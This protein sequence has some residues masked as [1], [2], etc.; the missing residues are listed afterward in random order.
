MNNYI[1]IKSFS[2]SI[3]CAALLLSAPSYGQDGTIEVN[4]DEPLRDSGANYYLV[5][6]LDDGIDRTH[7]GIE[8]M[9]IKGKTFYYGM[10]E[11]AIEEL[12]DVS[13][14]NVAVV[15]TLDVNAAEDATMTTT[16]SNDGKECNVD[17]INYIYEGNKLIEMEVTKPLV[18]SIGDFYGITFDT[19][20]KLLGEQTIVNTYDR[21]LGKGMVLY[22]NKSA[23]TYLYF[24]RERVKAWGVTSKDY[25]DESNWQLKYQSHPA[26]F[27]N[28]NSNGNRINGGA[29]TAQYGWYYYAQPTPNGKH[30]YKML[31]SGLEPTKLSEDSP[32]Y[33]NVYGDWLYYANMSDLTLNGEGKIY[34]IKTDGSERQVLTTI[35]AQYLIADEEALY[36]CSQGN[37]D[38]IVPGLY[39]I[40]KEGGELTFLDEG[41]VAYLNSSEEAL[42]YLIDSKGELDEIKKIDKEGNNLRTYM[43]GHFGFLYME[44]DA[45]FYSNIDEGHKAYVMSTYGDGNKINVVST[46][47]VVSMNR[48][49][50]MTIYQTIFNEYI[51]KNK[52][53]GKDYIK[54]GSLQYDNLQII[55]NKV[56]YLQEEEGGTKLY[57]K[58]L[59]KHEYQVIEVEFEEDINK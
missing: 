30:L 46:I 9:T 29:M 23:Y 3:V 1:K 14:E 2:V 20:K 40:S 5:T 59:W 56:F 34:R 36:F 33:L 4:F 13:D 38:D 52:L 49:G 37:S 28:G 50:E 54:E 48:W 43:I 41:N 18:T 27:H 39:K 57:Q 55:D 8:A 12:L 51:L 11:E 26:Y 32:S 25:R 45:L 31:S 42:Y 19:M 35:G 15:F 16:L 53:Y 24:E 58:H 22:K 7:S 47:P 10:S 17:G 6:D 21:V 44:A